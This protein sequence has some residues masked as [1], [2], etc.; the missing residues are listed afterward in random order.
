MKRSALI[1]WIIVPIQLAAIGFFLWDVGAGIVGLRTEPISWQLREAIEVGSALGLIIG[2]S[3]G[4]RLLILTTRRNRIVERQL[5]AAS[6]A[7][8][9]LLEERFQSWGLTPAERDVAWFTLKGYSINEIAELRK[10]SDGTVKA[11]S[12]AIYRKA[13]VSGRTQLLSMFIEDL[14]DVDDRPTPDEPIKDRAS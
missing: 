7:F 3:V 14:L 4:L 12:Y 13:D 2:F 6:G 5:R 1:L 8:A 11:Q 9:E 10:T